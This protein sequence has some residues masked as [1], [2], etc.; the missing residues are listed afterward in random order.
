MVD[1]ETIRLNNFAALEV[2]GPNRIFVQ[3]TAQQDEFTLD[4]SHIQRTSVAFTYRPHADEPTS[5]AEHCPLAVEP[6]WKPAGDKL[7]LLLQY[8]RNPAAAA[9]A[10]V[11]L[12]N[13][14]F[15]ATYEGARASGAQTRPAGTHLKDKHLVYWRVGDVALTDDWAKIVCRIVGDQGAEPKP[16]H[17]EVRWEY[18]PPAG[19]ERDVGSGISV[20]RLQEGKGKEKAVVDDDDPFADESVSSPPPTGGTWVDVPLLKKLVSGRY[21]AK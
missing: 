1:H 5:L 14:V 8:R 18:N 7:Q 12:H 6:T 17:V 11:R 13:V 21:E 15:V 9:P 2:I 3:N 16:G 20:S 4:T 19:S 10:P